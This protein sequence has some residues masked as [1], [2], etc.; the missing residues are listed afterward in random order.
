MLSRQPPGAGL[1]PRIV[2]VLWH[3]GQENNFSFAMSIFRREISGTIFPHK[4]CPMKKKHDRILFIAQAGIL[5]ETFSS[6]LCVQ[7]TLS[8]WWCRRSLSLYSS[9]MTSLASCLHIRPWHGEWGGRVEKEK[10]KGEQE[11]GE[12]EMLKQ[13]MQTGKFPLQSFLGIW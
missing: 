3:R 8:L 10:R 2:E 4:L 13:K 1:L 6:F 9:R 5:E 12:C 11:R 7:H